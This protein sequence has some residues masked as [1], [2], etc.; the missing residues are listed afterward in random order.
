MT[1]KT[2]EFVKDVRTFFSEHSDLR[3]EVMT[4]DNIFLF[5]GITRQYDPDSDTLRIDLR[6]GET[7]PAGTGA[8]VRIKIQIKLS[9][10]QQEIVLLY[11]TAVH[12]ERTYWDIM[13]EKIDYFT[14][15][16]MNFRLSVDIE[17]QIKRESNPAGVWCRLF[18]ISLTGAGIQL[19]EDYNVGEILIFSGFQIVK[20][21]F[22]HSFR[23][24]IVRKDRPD[25]DEEGRVCYRYGCKFIDMDERKRDILCRDVFSLQAQG[26]REKNSL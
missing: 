1:S 20:D 11:G 21:G 26:M 17:G 2:D 9:S 10:S 7:T 25:T 23:A 24:E 16:R 14:E 15:D 12:C 6:R 8:G 3:C 19:T 22:S 5:P 4:L 13:P 18:N